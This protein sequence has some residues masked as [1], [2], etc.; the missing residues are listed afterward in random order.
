MSK[1]SRDLIK[2][3]TPENRNL[4]LLLQMRMGHYMDGEIT[5]CKQV[6]ILTQNDR[7]YICPA[8]N[9]FTG[10][11]NYKPLQL[12]AEGDLFLSPIALQG[13]C[14][15]IG[16]L[17]IM[18]GAEELAQ[19]M[20]TVS[21]LKSAPA[22]TKGVDV[23]VM[24]NEMQSA[25]GYSDGLINPELVITQDAIQRRLVG[26]WDGPGWDEG[27]DEETRRNRLFLWDKASSMGE[28]SETTKRQILEATNSF[29]N[30]RDIHGGYYR[31][32]IA[33]LPESLPLPE[34]GRDARKFFH[35]TV[36]EMMQALPDRSDI[37][38][39]LDRAPRQSPIRIHGESEMNPNY[40]LGMSI[41]PEVLATIDAWADPE[42]RSAAKSILSSQT[43]L[44]DSEY[45]NRKMQMPGYQPAKFSFWTRMG[46]KWAD[47]KDRV[48]RFFSNL[49]KR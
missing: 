44:S 26:P 30:V 49:F 6:V 3:L 21:A 14:N 22:A 29:P 7:E 37:Q 24:G 47:L 33:D 25:A 16:V 35:A 23:V 28:V 20:R 19:T 38:I 2:N 36:G 32:P 10:R 34:G 42:L 13:G 12:N 45:F 8:A 31:N 40:P 18:V 15:F 27:M 5:I 41:N 9:P 39:S 17:D 1:A 48:G 46:W 43:P 4:V 11:M